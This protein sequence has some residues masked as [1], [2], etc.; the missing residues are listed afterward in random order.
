MIGVLL[1]NLGG[2]DSLAAVRPFL[3][4]LFS[5]REIIRLGPAPL[6]KPIAGLISLLRSPKTRGFYSLIGGKSPLREITAA[7]AQALEASLR[8]VTDQPLKVYMGM[9]YWHPFTG[10]TVEEMRKDGV[11]KVL[12]LTLYPHY[13]IATTGS[14]VRHFRGI[15][16][17]Y[18]MEIH[19][20]ESWYN[21]PLYIDSLV[22]KIREGMAGFPERPAVL[23]SAHSLPQKFIDEGDPY[24]REIKGT[25]AAITQRVDMDWSLSF[26]SKTGPVKW[27]EPSTECMLHELAGKGVKNLL[28]VP[29][30]F[31]SDHIETLYEIDILYGNM[32][33]GL[34]IN[35]RR[36]ESLNTSPVFINALTDLA[37]TDLKGLGWI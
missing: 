23:F 15:V 32:A 26:Q 6:Q 22:E 8:Q 17:R 1:L 9:R 14:S 37:V 24:E 29:I 35:M 3:Y 34:G 36:T 25:I 30:S 27:L 21:H 28:V 16:S 18:P 19:C 11:T 12:A 10:E 31:V 2:P 5:D 13:S 20:K 4:N 7:Q 33:R